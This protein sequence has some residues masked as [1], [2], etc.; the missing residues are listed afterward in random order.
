M[1]ATRA[2][3]GGFKGL[4]S[5]RCTPFVSQ[6]PLMSSFFDLFLAFSGDIP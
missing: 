5:K 4:Y 6:P 3:H 2:E 1:F